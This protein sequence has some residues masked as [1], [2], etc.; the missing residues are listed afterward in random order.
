MVKSMTAAVAGLRAHQSKMDVIGNN[1]ANVNTNG[2]K[3]SRTTFQESMYQSISASS[4]GSDLYGGTNPS[5]LGYG[6]QVSSIDLMFTTGAPAPTNNSTD[7]MIDGNGFFLVG[8]KKQ[9]ILNHISP[10]DDG[11]GGGGDLEVAG[12]LEQLSFTRYGNFTLDGD[13]YLKDPAGNVVY[14]FYEGM[15][16]NNVLAMDYTKLQPI[17]VPA[18]KMT[19]TDGTEV[20]YNVFDM[21]DTSERMVLGNLRID[22]N[23]NLIGTNEDNKVITVAQLAIANVPNPNA[24]EKDTGPYFNAIQNTGTIEAFA[25]GEGTTGLVRGSTLEMSNVDIAQ[26]FSDMITTQRGFQANTRIITVTD[27]MLQE[28]VN[29]KR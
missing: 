29:I 20:D 22:K 23:G 14:G 13:G 10:D 7:V 27:E 15:D 9:E 28:L 25:A 12:E 24:L 21:S 16:D 19:T 6:S 18:N 11:N 17:R 8:P 1:I 2:F 3:A 4:Q 5:Q 26:E